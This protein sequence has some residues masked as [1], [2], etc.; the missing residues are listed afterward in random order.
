MRQAIAILLAVCFA[1]S[2]RAEWWSKSTKVFTNAAYVVAPI[3]SVVQS[4]LITADAGGAIFNVWDGSA[5][6]T[7][8]NASDTGFEWVY[9]PT[10]AFL[11]NQILVIH[12]ASNNFYQ[13]AVVMG[14]TNNGTDS[15]IWLTNELSTCPLIREV[16]PGDKIFRMIPTTW[17]RVHGSNMVHYSSPQGVWKT[18]SGFPTL[19]QLQNGAGIYTNWDIF[20]G[21]R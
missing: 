17:R 14:V 19:F 11:T 10:N 12:S 5:A 13:R 6:V 7:I 9:A 16:H 2:A 4:L 3:N 8:T 21:G 15:I 20:I 1:T 18:E